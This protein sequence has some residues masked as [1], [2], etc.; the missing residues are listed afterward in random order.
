MWKYDRASQGTGD[1]IKLRRKD[2]IRIPYNYGKNTDTLIVF[3]TFLRNWLIASELVKCL[4][5]AMTK[6]EK[7][8]NDL[9]DIAICL[10][11]FYV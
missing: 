3:K 4:T 7:L 9:H 2:A 1:N 10:A 6:V 8:R 5:A 11:K